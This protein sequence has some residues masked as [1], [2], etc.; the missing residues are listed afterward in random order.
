MREKR[1]E[2]DGNLLSLPMRQGYTTFLQ[3][4]LEILC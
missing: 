4:K 2:E 3:L 1:Q